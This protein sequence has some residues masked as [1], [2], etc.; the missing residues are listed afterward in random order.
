MIHSVL[1]LV[2]MFEYQ[3]KSKPAWSFDLYTGIVG[4]WGFIISIPTCAHW[5]KTVLCWVTHNLLQIVNFVCN[6]EI[7]QNFCSYWCELLE[8][9]SRAVECT[10]GTEEWHRAQLSCSFR[11]VCSVPCHCKCGILS[12]LCGVSPAPRANNSVQCGLGRFP[13][14]SWF[15]QGEF[16]KAKMGKTR[17]TKGFVGWSSSDL[18]VGR[19]ECRWNGR[20]KQGVRTLTLPWGTAE[21]LLAGE[22]PVCETLLSWGGKK[23]TLHWSHPLHFMS[24]NSAVGK[25]VVVWRL[26]SSLNLL[27]LWY[28]YSFLIYGHDHY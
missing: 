18:F 23:K 1:N 15:W 19:D 16:V 13:G 17:C 9:D 26:L 20:G 11:A 4:T 22:D 2:Q 3:I 10:R 27:Q 12:Q 5:Q 24:V 21:Q 14:H 8:L 25:L 7:F 6:A 28:Y